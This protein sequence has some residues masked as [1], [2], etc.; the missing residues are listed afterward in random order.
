MWVFNGFFQWAHQV[1]WVR[2]WVSEPGCTACCNITYI[3]L[4]TERF[5]T[6][7]LI[8]LAAISCGAMLAAMLYE[9]FC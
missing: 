9:M 7:W 2:T 4:L 3:F 6:G 1:F 8:E 5:A